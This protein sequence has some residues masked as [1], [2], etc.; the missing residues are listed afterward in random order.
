[1][2]LN[3][4]NSLTFLI[5][6]FLWAVLHAFAYHAAYKPIFTMIL[7]SGVRRKLAADQGKASA[8]DVSEEDTRAASKRA[9]R[10]VWDTIFH[11]ASA[12][13][14]IAVLQLW[15]PIFSSEAYFRGV[16]SYGSVANGG[17]ALPDFPALN[18]Y[19]MFLT[20]VFSY[21]A[22]SLWELLR[23]EDGE[24]R[25][26]NAVMLSHHLATMLLIFLCDQGGF[27]RIGVAI[28]VL[29]DF[30]DIFLE[31]G[32]SLIY[33]GRKRAADILFACFVASWFYTRLYLYP[34]YLL[35]YIWIAAPWAEWPNTIG[36]AYVALTALQVMHAW[37]TVPI[38]VLLRKIMKG[39]QVED[40]REQ[41]KKKK[42]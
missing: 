36:I 38:L 34:R 42:K 30:A 28:I 5:Y 40:T 32:K 11:T 7:R 2:N 33:T 3:E 8:D 9:L 16:N 6:A 19:H 26:D 27:R 41:T 18:L 39:G 1:M 4:S 35:Y 13:A 10:S 20:A 23:G 22:Y 24:A 12:L 37:W 14:G 29:H 15:A 31:C 17:G 25:S 21:Y